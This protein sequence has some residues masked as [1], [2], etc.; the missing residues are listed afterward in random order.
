MAHKVFIAVLEV[1]LAQ[2]PIFSSAARSSWSQS[3]WQFQSAATWLTAW[4][5]HPNLGS[6]K[7]V[8]EMQ[9]ERNFCGKGEDPGVE[10]IH[11]LM[12][13]VPR[14]HCYNTGNRFVVVKENWFIHHS[15][16]KAPVRLFYAAV[17]FLFLGLRH[18]LRLFSVFPLP[19]SL[20]PVS[21]LPPLLSICHMQIAA[22][23]WEEK[24]NYFRNCCFHTF[25]C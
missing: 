20:I 5:Q 13:M 24:Q 7:E 23:R 12:G 18:E 2:I 22:L 15:L 14:N 4:P 19:L 11:R 21:C 9:H 3:W 16:W 8:W 6:K 10:I 25:P 1:F 17:L